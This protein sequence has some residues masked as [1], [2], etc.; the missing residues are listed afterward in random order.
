[1]IKINLKFKTLEI[2][3]SV[4]YRWVVQ[5]KLKQSKIFQSKCRVRR[6]FPKRHQK[7]TGYLLRMRLM[8]GIISS[9]KV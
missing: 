6:N 2:I 8:K 9:I 7:L 1:M 4:N 5:L 3:D